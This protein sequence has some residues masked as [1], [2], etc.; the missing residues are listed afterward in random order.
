MRRLSLFIVS[1]AAALSLQARAE[2]T[3]VP[4]PPQVAVDPATAEPEVKI[5]KRGEDTIE[6]YRLNGHLYMVKITPSVGLPY[7]LMDEGG[8][9]Q[10]RQIDPVRRVI[11]PQWVLLRF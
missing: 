6:E 1:A 3:P 10:M 8:N 5:I 4:A 9:G 11:I 2:T 7:Y